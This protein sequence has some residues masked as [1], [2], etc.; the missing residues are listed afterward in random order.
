MSSSWECE[1]WRFGLKIWGDSVSIRSAGISGSNFGAEVKLWG[2]FPLLTGTYLWDLSEFVKD[3]FEQPWYFLHWKNATTPVF[4]RYLWIVCVFPIIYNSFF[5]NHP[6]NCR[7]HPM[8]SIK[9]SAGFKNSPPGAE[10]VADVAGQCGLGGAAMMFTNRS[11]W[12]VS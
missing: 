7:N 3:T 12:C 10:V 11:E 6:K 1:V 2:E 9:S 8:L 4:L 5:F